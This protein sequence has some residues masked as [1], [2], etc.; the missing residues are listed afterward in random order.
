LLGHLGLEEI[1][2]L[3]MGASERKKGILSKHM[4]VVGKFCGFAQSIFTFLS[5]FH[6]GKM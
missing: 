6:Y 2:S 3:V 1:T 4:D 5:N